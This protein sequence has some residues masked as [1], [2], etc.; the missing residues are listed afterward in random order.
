MTRTY[1]ASPRRVGAGQ[2]VDGRDVLRVALS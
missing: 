1:A 2:F